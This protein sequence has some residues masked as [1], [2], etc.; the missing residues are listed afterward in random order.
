MKKSVLVAAA[1]LLGVGSANASGWR[2]PEQSVNS[3]ARSGGYVAY[4]PA[5][6][7]TYYNPANMSWLENRWMIE[8]DAT[9]IRLTSIDYTDNLSSAYSGSS[10][11]ENFL[12]PTFFAVSPDYNGFRFGFSLTAPA[13]LS[14]QWKDPYPRTYAEE[15]TLKVFEAN[16]TVS[17]NFNDKFSI[18]GGVRIL[19][20]DG[21][22]KSNSPELFPGSGTLSRDMEGDTIEYGYNLAATFRPV[23]SLNLAVT[24]R[25]NI[26][27]DVEGTATLKSPAIPM[28]SVP[29]GILPAGSYSGDAAVSSPVP[30]V[31]AI[32]ASYT[33]FDQLTI[34]LEYDRTFWSEYE[35]LDFSYSPSLTDPRMAAFDTPG[36]RNWSDT[37]TY[38]ISFE[39]DFKNNFILMGGFAIDE[40]PA[41]EEHVGFELPDS[42]AQLY[43]I[44]MRYLVS[45]NVELG[46][47]YLYDKK[48]SRT[49]N[50]DIIH[51]EFEDASAHLVTVGLSYKF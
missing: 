41:P 12:L 32:A 50:N 3:T 14:K 39:Y 31:L 16:P 7:A 27:L 37:D 20:A 6:D 49:V 22:V 40:N 51:G 19:Y 30:A 15:F 23:E 9:W 43:S 48:E 10:E 34:E 4:T 44:G 24:Y 33:F 17:Y 1:L 26:D 18:G 38:R 2:V 47:A 42:D 25:S 46:I 45:E 29:G 13:G 28:G 8:F 11:E 21:K 5:A 36:T 35:T